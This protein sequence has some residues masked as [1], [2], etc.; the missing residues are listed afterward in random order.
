VAQNVLAEMDKQTDGVHIM[1]YEQLKIENHVHLEKIEERNEDIQKLKAKITDIL[2]VLTHLKEKMFCIE[3]ESQDSKEHVY[4]LE[5]DLARKRSEL[6]RTKVPDCLLFF[7]P[8]PQTHSL[9]HVC[10]GCAI[11]CARTISI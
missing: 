11:S 2:Q 3:S 4:T 7:L 6:S 5:R 9:F 8:F 1:H 10:S